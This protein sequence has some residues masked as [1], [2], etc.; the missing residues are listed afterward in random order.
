MWSEAEGH[1]FL[2]NWG[3]K[4]LFLAFTALFKSSFTST[5]KVDFI[6]RIKMLKLNLARPPMRIWLDEPLSFNENPGTPAT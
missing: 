6:F 2:Q 4:E 1:C 3:G 5:F